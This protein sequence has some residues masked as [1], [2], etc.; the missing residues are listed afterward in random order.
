MHRAKRAIALAGVLTAF[1]LGLKDVSG[2]SSLPVT[3]DTQRAALFEGA[4]LIVGDGRLLEDSAFIVENK[5]FT[6]IGKK[7][8]LELPRGGVQIDLTGKTVMPALVDLH[9]HPGY[10]NGAAYAAEN[11]TRGNIIDHLNRYAYYG[12]GTVV[13]LGTDVGDVAFQI[14]EEQQTGRLGGAL[15][16]T[17]GRGLAA[18][19][20]GS[21]NP[22]M[23]GAAYEA[24]TVKEARRNVQELA[25]QKV[26]L[27]KVYVDDRNGTVPKLRPELYRAVI[28]EAHKHSLRVVAHVFYLEDAKDLVR[29]GV[30]GFSHLARD[31]EVDDEFVSFDETA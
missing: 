4:R 5:R 3:S 26:D 6:R 16:R 15:L 14:R 13:G 17:A 7:G 10:L 25:I 23:R 21:A 12:I 30:D 29:A 8:E 11:Y 9:A 19:N 27:I 20:A 2:Q 1:S 18:P 31:R 28:D 24:E 22:A